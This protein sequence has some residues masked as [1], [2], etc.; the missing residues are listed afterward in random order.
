MPSEEEI[1]EYWKKVEA[2]R[3]QN[4]EARAARRRGGGR[5]RRGGRRG[6]RG[7]RRYEGDD[8]EAVDEDGN[9][10]QVCWSL[11]NRMIHN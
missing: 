4:R 3:E 11:H 2:T 10:L 9:R 5:G 1:A 6:G 8:E 7:G